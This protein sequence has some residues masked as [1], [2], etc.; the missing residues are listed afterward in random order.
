[1]SVD[2]L[3]SETFPSNT[4]QKKLRLSA[5]GTPAMGAKHQFTL[6]KSSRSSSPVW[7]VSLE[8][9]VWLTKR[10]LESLTNERPVEACA[11]IRASDPTV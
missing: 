8:R 11:D 6:G 10:S 1:M 5:N 7:P 4:G 9:T 3:Y 2:R